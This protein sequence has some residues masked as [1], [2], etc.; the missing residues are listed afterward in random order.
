MQWGLRELFLLWKGE[1]QLKRE[2]WYFDMTTVYRKSL[3]VEITEET[4]TRLLEGGQVCAA[5]F[6]C[7]DCDSKQCLWRLCLESCV[8][9]VGPNV[10]ERPIQGVCQSP[11][12]CLRRRSIRRVKRE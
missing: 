8:N 12:R 5:D 4:L 7:L 11:G 2:G 6:C 1:T 3:R 9:N 10:G